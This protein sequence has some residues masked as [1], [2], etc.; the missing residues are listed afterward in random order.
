MNA[1][2]NEHQKARAQALAL[3]VD[4]TPCPRCKRPM[5]HWQKLDYDHVVPLCLGGAMDGQRLLSHA[6]CNRSAGAALGNRL[7]GKTTRKPKRRIK[8]KPRW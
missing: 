6:K 4:G 2:G 8:R 1:Y 5:H 7:R 3:L